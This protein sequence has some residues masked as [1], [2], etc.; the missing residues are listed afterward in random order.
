[1]A[2]T[3]AFWITTGLFS[4][5]L[6]AS[7]VMYLAGAMTPVIAELGYP[8]HFVYLLGTFKILGVL[9][10]LIPVPRAI[11]EWAYAGFAINL[12]S[13]FV[14]HAAAGHGVD[15][16]IAPVILLSLLIASYLLRKD[17]LAW[18]LPGTA[19]LTPQQA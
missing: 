4:L 14:A 5:A 18:L 3:I 9:A 7:G 10:L 19:G 13:A 6:G 11:K 1:M 12:I 16:L 17:A 2:R 8:E 15:K